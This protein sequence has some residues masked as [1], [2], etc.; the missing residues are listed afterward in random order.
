[1]GASEY[2]ADGLYLVLAYFAC[3]PCRIEAVLY[4][5]RPVTDSFGELDKFSV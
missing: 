2:D 5:F 3:K 4:G 1:M